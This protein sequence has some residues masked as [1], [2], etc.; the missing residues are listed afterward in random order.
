MRQKLKTGN[1]K[2]ENRK[3]CAAA[4]SL[5]TV[6]CTFLLAALM[7]ASGCATTT[8][9][10]EERQ[11]ATLTA[12]DITDNTLNINADK[13]FKY[14]IYKPSDPYKAIVELPDVKLGIAAGKIK[15]EKAGITEIVP[16]QTDEPPL[17]KLEILLSSPA[18]IVPAYKGTLLTLNIINLEEELKAKTTEKAAETPK[19]EETNIA[20]EKIEDA[21]KETKLVEIA[22]PE[23]KPKTAEKE[24]PALPKAAAPKELP[25]ATSIVKVTIEKEQDVLKLTIK[26]NGSLNPNV[27]ELDNRTVLDMP[28]V[29]LEAP[30]PKAQS[31][32]KGIRAGKYKDK[33]RIVL[34]MKEKTSFAVTSIED[35]VIVSFQLPEKEKYTAK[36]E[37][38]AETVPSISGEPEKPVEGKYKGQKISLDFQDAD[39]GPIFRLLADISGY[40][41]VID[42]TVKGKITLKLMNVPWDQALDI[43][44]QTFGLGKSVEG[45]IVWIA[46]VSMF[47]KMSDEKT[48]AKDVEEKAEELMQEIIRINYATSSEISGAIDKGKLLSSRG[49]VTIDNRMNTLIIKDTQ[50]SI[51]KIKE[52]VKIMDVAKS[53]VMIEAKIVEVGSNYSESMGIR[54]GGNLGSASPRVGFG[55]IDINSGTFSVNTPIVTA[56]SATTNAGG[57]LGLSLGSASTVQVNLSLSAL[58]SVGKSRR[59]SNPKIMTMDNEAATIQQG[60]SIPV[61]TVSAEGTK[62]EY[63]NATLSLGVTP[64]ITPDGYVQLKINATNNALGILTP[65]GYAIETKS[66]NTQALVKNGDTL[67]IGGIYTTN[68][69]EGEEGIPLLRSIP[70]L[71][72]LFKTKTQTGPN[73][74]E[75]LIFI[76]PTIVTKP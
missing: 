4:S 12:I 32:L 2:T 9:I 44:L 54:W 72:W 57:V 48:K 11:I 68:T 71:G 40:N 31:P 1:Q 3:K 15:S 56:G 23:E 17:T 19:A 45:N 46:P 16:S 76:T 64:R 59:L 66:V 53:Q 75:L 20:A 26:G 22:K 69:S 74:T 65:Q 61:Q 73:V 13:P 14:T 34:D 49:A 29:T 58:E 52:L 18:G 36:A 38:K 27:F 63:V 5:P 24:E 35:S 50:K 25:P 33:T 43:I 28:N 47:A 6:I 8:G 7:L 10:Q 55:N 51:N 37:K 62:T 21:F 67:V 30:L 42:P 60:V 70:L 41:F 39:I